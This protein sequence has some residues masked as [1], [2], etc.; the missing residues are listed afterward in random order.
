[1]F[2]TKL[3]GYDE[4]KT[5]AYQCIT[6]YYNNLNILLTQA[7]VQVDALYGSATDKDLSDSSTTSSYNIG[8]VTETIKNGAVSSSF[9]PSA[10]RFTHFI[11][12]QV[13]GIKYCIASYIYSSDSFYMSNSIYCQFAVFV[14]F[15]DKE[16]NLIDNSRC[17]FC[18]YI[19]S[20]YEYIWSSSSS[21][22]FK[23]YL[24][25][26]DLIKNNECFFLMLRSYSQANPGE[27]FQ[28][29]HIK[30]NGEYK[31]VYPFVKDVYLDKG[32][33]LIATKVVSTSTVFS[34][35]LSTSYT[36][37]DKYSETIPTGDVYY[38]YSNNG[39]L[40][41]CETMLSLPYD[42][43]YRTDVII[44]EKKYRKIP[45]TTSVYYEMLD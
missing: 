16:G 28:I 2:V 15:K 23:N 17:M 38:G 41:K 30:W 5:T 6:D 20:A 13:D 21:S 11:A 32:E 33:T 19:L 8:W 31:T 40:C 22:G 45:K 9:T 14:D 35:V 34:P 7:G 29:G 25:Y 24:C 36:E 43:N 4:T 26:I 3:C 37:G 10:K 27:N 39:I 18:Y 44:G 42:I 1:M 12:F